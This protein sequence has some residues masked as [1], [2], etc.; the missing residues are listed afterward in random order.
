MTGEKG[1]MQAST[2]QHDGFR[3]GLE[4]FVDYVWHCIA[5]EAKYAAQELVRI[6]DGFEPV[7]WQHLNDE[8]PAFVDLRKYSE[9]LKGFHSGFAVEAEKTHRELG[10][11]AGAVFL[12]A[13]HDVEY[14]DGIHTDFPPIPS[15]ISWGL[16]NVAW[17]VH[18]D[19][20]AFAPCD[21]S[22]KMRPL[23]IPSA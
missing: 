23:D 9:R 5:G 3:G 16:R 20:W 6:I 7:L 1:I 12:M 10:I 19:W 2:E 18:R 13:T 22:G 14:E 4:T 11:L 17:W 15:A 21:R 8:I